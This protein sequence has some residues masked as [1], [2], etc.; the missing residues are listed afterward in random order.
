M[1]DDGCRDYGCGGS[2]DY[3]YTPPTNDNNNDDEE[4]DDGGSVEIVVVPAYPDTLTYHPFDGN[5]VYD[6]P[7]YDDSY[8]PRKL[9]GHQM[10]L[11][12]QDDVH[13]SWRNFLLPSDPLT[14]ASTAENAGEGLLWVA[15]KSLGG[16]GKLIAPVVCPECSVLSFAAAIDSL[17]SAITIDGHLETKIYYTYQ[18]PFNT[19]F[20]PKK[21]R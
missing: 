1:M 5:L 8:F 6:L 4:E 16:L 13:W 15:G 2:S 3:V 14:W 20:D 7:I 17:N 21:I 12:T 11:Y 18:S 19:P 9:I 10:L